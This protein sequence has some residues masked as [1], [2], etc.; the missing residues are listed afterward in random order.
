MSIDFSWV[1][2]HDQVKNRYLSVSQSLWWGD[3]LDVRF[4]LLRHVV[5]LKCKNI[6]DIGC[7]IGV[8]ISFLDKTNI[9]HG[10]DID[11]YCVKKAKIL[12]PSAMIYQGSMDNLPYKDNTFDIILMMNVLPYYDF[13]IDHEIKNI[14]IKNTMKEIYRVLKDDGDLYFTTPNGDYKLYKNQK[15]TVDE[16]SDILKDFN[17]NI[18]GW[19]NLPIYLIKLIPIKFLSKLESIWSK[20]V[21]DAQTFRRNRSKYFYIKATKKEI[22]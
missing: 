2:F 8:S 20:L 3:D 1:K 14:F 11:S 7:N 10:I 17:F 5:N 12:N 4:Y 15:V 13:A 22:P 9:L 18:K 21:A 6:L 16:L 19:N